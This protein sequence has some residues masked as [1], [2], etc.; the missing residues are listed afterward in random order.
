MCL[1]YDQYYDQYSVQLAVTNLV[2]H[3]E[4]LKFQ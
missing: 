1:Y 2:F 4:C 3:E